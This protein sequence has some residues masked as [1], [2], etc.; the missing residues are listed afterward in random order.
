MLLKVFFVG[1]VESTLPVPNE[2]GSARSR[3]S[4]R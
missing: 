1:Y 4:S 3:L 2:C